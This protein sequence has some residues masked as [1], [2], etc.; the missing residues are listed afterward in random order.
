MKYAYIT[1]TIFSDGEIAV[2]ARNAEGRLLFGFRT[3]DYFGWRNQAR[4]WTPLG[5]VPVF[6]ANQSAEMR[7]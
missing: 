5:M 3:R 2:Q 1:K 7:A 6:Q 4:A